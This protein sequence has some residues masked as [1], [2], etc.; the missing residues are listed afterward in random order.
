MS[1]EPYT[2]LPNISI[3]GLKGPW[4]IAASSSCLYVSDKGSSAIWRVKTAN[5]KVDQWLSGLLA[6]SVSVTSEEK[7]VLMVAVD[8]QGSLKERNTNYRGEIQI[9]NAGAVKETVIKLSPDITSP[10]CRHDNEE[11]IYCQLWLPMA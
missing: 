8:G 3:N 9:Y 6:A 4:G 11:D 5:S 1:D 2:R 10:H 7:L